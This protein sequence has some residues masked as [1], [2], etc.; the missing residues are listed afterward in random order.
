MSKLRKMSWF[1]DDAADIPEESS[2]E[3]IA[4]SIDELLARS[5]REYPERL[6]RRIV[7]YLEMHPVFIVAA[8]NLHYETRCAF[9]QSKFFDRRALVEAIRRSPLDASAILT[10]NHVGAGISWRAPFAL[11]DKGRKIVHKENDC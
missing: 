10:N 1:I 5:R 6:E 4:E 9:N 7:A 3:P 11:T 8:L 2:P